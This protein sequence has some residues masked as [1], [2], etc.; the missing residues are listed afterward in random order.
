LCGGGICAFRTSVSLAAWPV[1][2]M[3]EAVDRVHLKRFSVE[4]DN[5]LFRITVRTSLAEHV[6]ICDVHTH[7]RE[8]S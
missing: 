3:A 1:S 6:Q 5:M 4:I 2:C 7:P 8:A